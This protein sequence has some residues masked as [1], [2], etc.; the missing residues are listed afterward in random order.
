MAGLEVGAV[1]AA[2]VG[3]AGVVTG[4]ALMANPAR[5]AASIGLK[6][7]EAATRFYARTCGVRNLAVGALFLYGAYTVGVAHAPGKIA[8]AGLA[9]AWAA[10][11]AGDAA[12]FASV[13]SRPG[14]VG[15]SV[16]AVASAATVWLALAG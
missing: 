2:L 6:V 7:G 14:A 13:R 5:A 15:A 12:L 3:L 10:V 1:L 9:V 16:L 8:L 4:A 11:Q